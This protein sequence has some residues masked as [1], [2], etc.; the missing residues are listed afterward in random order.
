MRKRLTP[1]PDSPPNS[2]SSL[3][4]DAHTQHAENCTAQN[5][6]LGKRRGH[7][8]SRLGCLNCKRRRVKCNEA[9][10]EC[11][12]CR[13]LGLTCEYPATYA[14]AAPRANPSPLNLQDL[15]FYHQFLSVASPPLPL[16]EPSVWSQCAAMSHDVSCGRLFSFAF[17]SVADFC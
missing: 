8:K 16:R 15:R 2:S 12:P 9:R 10:P 1:P 14:L 5:P 7:F 13:R 4:P 17:G 3:T 11:S 6:R